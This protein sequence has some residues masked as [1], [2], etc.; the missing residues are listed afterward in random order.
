M[1]KGLSKFEIKKTVFARPI[2]PDF[3]VGGIAA[4]NRIGSAGA[5]DLSAVIVTT[6]GECN[7][8]GKE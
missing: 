6:R 7:G 2:A 8:F 3:G 5:I 1:R 4:L